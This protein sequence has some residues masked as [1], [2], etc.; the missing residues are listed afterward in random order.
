MSSLGAFGE[1]YAAAQLQK[2]GYTITAQNYHS[3]YGEIDSIAV[4]ADIIVF[5]EV[6][7]RSERCRYAPREAVTTAKMKK[8]TRTAACYLQQ[9]PCE[10]QPRFDV[11][12]LVVIDKDSLSVLSYNHIIGAFD[13]VY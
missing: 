4:V 7:A 3:R 9:N 11:I 13:A 2:L 10:L 12:E 6:K 1:Q 8:I 5:A